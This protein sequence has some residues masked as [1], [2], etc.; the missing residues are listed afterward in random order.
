MISMA[1][2]IM[3]A[4]FGIN[5]TFDGNISLKIG[6]YLNASA[7]NPKTNNV[8]GNGDILEQDQTLSQSNCNCKKFSFTLNFAINITGCRP[9]L[10][11]I[12]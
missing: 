11:T 2:E 3:A 8:A 9:Y 5:V 12:K 10:W 1:N 7:N 6:W 4:I